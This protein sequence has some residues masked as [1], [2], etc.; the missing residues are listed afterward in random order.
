MTTANDLIQNASYIAGILGEGETL[1]AGE[2]AKGL[3]RLNS[4]L[5]SWRLDKLMVYQI[6]ERTHTLVANTKSYTVGSGGDIDIERPLNIADPCFIREDSMD[7]PVKVITQKGYGSITPKSTVTSNIPGYLFYDPAYPLGTIYL[8]PAPSTANVLHFS[9]WLELQYFDTLVEEMSLPP[10]YQEAIEYNLG[11]R[12]GAMQGFPIS[13]ENKQIAIQSKAAIKKNN[14]RTLIS[15][16][17]FAEK[18]RR[19]NIMAD[20]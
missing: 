13:Q 16:V 12:L 20:V 8:Y 1:S 11:S 6:V 14:R 9:T 19:Y 15:R 2:A 3:N 10:G 5:D 18:G 4:M 7:Y 17:E